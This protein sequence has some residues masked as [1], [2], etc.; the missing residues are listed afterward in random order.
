VRGGLGMARVDDEAG[1]VVFFAPTKR[2]LSICSTRSGPRALLPVSIKL[3]RYPQSHSGLL[4][5]KE[6]YDLVARPM[7]QLDRSHCPVL[8][9]R[10]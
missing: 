6:Q 9:G 5:G 8:T 10:S 7:F 1:R 3:N 4:T 2:I